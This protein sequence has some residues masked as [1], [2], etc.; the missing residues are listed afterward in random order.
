MKTP[1]TCRLHNGAS[2]TAF[3]AALISMRSTFVYVGA[4]GFTVKIDT[5]D[6]C[7]LREFALA[8]RVHKGR[9]TDGQGTILPDDVLTDAREYTLQPRQSSTLREREEA[10]AIAPGGVLTNHGRG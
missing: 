9:A 6:Q 2:E 10:N 7:A 1:F 8:L 3:A 5:E 4:F